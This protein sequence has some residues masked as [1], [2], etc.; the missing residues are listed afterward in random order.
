[1]NDVLCRALADARLREIDVAAALGVDP[2]TVQRWIAGRVP[3]PRHRWAVADLLKANEL[4]LWS[5]LKAA[6]PTC[7]EVRAVYPYRSAVPRSE[8]LRL[9][10][11]AE[12]EIDILAYAALFL[13][14]DAKIVQ[15]LGERAR[16][17]VSVRLLLADPNSPKIADRGAEEGI[18]SAVASR[19]R[20]ATALFQP[21][22][23]AQ[24]VQVR[25]HETVLYNSIFRAD[26]EMLINPQV[27]GI[28]AA[29]APVLHVRRVRPDDVFTTYADSFTRVWA[30]SAPGKAPESI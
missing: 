17:G 2:K 28:A 29:Y 10:G 18:G 19:V 24:G 26:D 8:W 25:Q 15:L 23:N 1:M 7:P 14:E 4:E 16:V 20:N 27:H 12:R 13:A 22:L 21:L 30:G 9:F 6:P 11:N 3:H 5:D